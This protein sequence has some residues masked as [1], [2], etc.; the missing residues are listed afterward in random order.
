MCQALPQDLVP[1]LLPGC[2]VAHLQLGHQSLQR[3]LLGR[4]LLPA[5]GAALAGPRAHGLQG[6][7]KLG[8]RQGR[9]RLRLGLG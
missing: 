1:L 9:Q 7:G 6:R 2:R 8:L 5:R 4:L 3:Q